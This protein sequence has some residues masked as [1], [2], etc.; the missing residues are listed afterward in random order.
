MRATILTASLCLPVL[1]AQAEPWTLMDLGR[2]HKE[3]HCLEAA[4]RTFRD[5]LGE[6]RIAGVSASDWVVFADGI[7]GMHDTL[8]SC[9]FGDNRGTRA[10]LVIHSSDRPI[11]AQLLKRRV[12]HLFAGHAKR[13]TRAWFDSFR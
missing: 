5:L 10:T 8:I 7:N 3:A 2:L 6:V 12:A 11:D 4:K 1:T 13:L 9:T